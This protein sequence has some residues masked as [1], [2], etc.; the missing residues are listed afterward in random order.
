MSDI[1]ERWP[2]QGIQGGIDHYKRWLSNAEILGG[3]GGAGQAVTLNEVRLSVIQVPFPMIVDALGV[4][5]QAGAAGGRQ[6]RYAIYEGDPTW[7]DHPDN[8]PLVIQSAAIT[9]PGNNR[10]CLASIPPTLLDA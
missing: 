5:I 10:Y 6:M 1:R 3:I 2:P 9:P 4:R 8:E 7:V